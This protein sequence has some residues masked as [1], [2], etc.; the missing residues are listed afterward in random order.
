MEK[1]KITK[2]QFIGKCMD[3]AEKLTRKEHNIREESHLSHQHWMFRNGA[4]AMASELLKEQY[5]IVE[6]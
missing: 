1:K 3:L 6:E 5:E 4:M 2:D